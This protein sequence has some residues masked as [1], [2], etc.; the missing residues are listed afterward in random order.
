[1]SDGA[2]RKAHIV[3]HTHWDREWYL[4]Y[5]QFR[6]RLGSIV[7][8]TLDLLDEGGDF[9]H[10]LLDGQAILLEDFLAVH[11]EEADRIRRLVTA[12]A[13]SI[14][15]W[16]VLS[17]E[18]L[19]SGEATVRNLLI[20]D[21]V[22]RAF[23]GAQKEGYMPDSFGHLAQMPQ[24]LRGAGIESFIY[25]RGHGDEIEDLGSE[26][27]WEAPDGSRVIAL[28]QVRGYCNAGGL[29][30][31][32]IWHAHTPRLVDVGRAIEQVRDLFSEMGKRSRGDSYLLNNGCDHFPP[33]QSFSEILAA[34]RTAFPAT[35]FVHTNLSAFVAAVRASGVATQVHRGELLQ[36][37]EHAILSGV[38]SARM[39]LKQMN[40][41]A[42][43]LLAGL[44][45]P[46]AAYAHCMHRQEYPQ[47]E[48]EAAWKLLLQNHPHDS[49][50]GCSIDPVHREME[51]RFAGVIEAGEYLIRAHLEALVPT[52]ARRGEDDDQTVLVVFNP[53]AQR[54]SEIVTRLV[55]LPLGIPLDELALFD[56]S[57]TQVPCEVLD[58]KYV[59][60]F[61]NVDY[62]R[63]LYGERQRRLF[64]VYLDHFGERIIKE[65][66]EKETCDGMVV[67]QFLARDL[68][69]VGH[70]NY[71][72]RPSGAQVR[73]PQSADS[74][75][76]AD[77]C[78]ANEFY[79]VNLR[80]DG[81]FALHDKATGRRFGGLNRIADG[82]DIG[83]EYD[84]SPCPHPGE[85][86]PEGFIG[87]VQIVTATP[88]CAEIE[89]SGELELPRAITSD[90]S[91]RLAE[92]IACPFKTRVRLQRHSRLIEIETHFENRAHD[93]RL[94]I[95]FPTSIA[96]DTV[97]SDGQFLVIP[98]PIEQPARAGWVQSP[99]G[100]VP[101]QAFSLIEDE[102]GGLAI[103]NKGLPE[104]EAERNARGGTTLALTLLRCVDWLSRDDFPSRN[105]ANAGPTL[106]TPEA[107]C[108]G[109]HTFEYALVPYAG[110]YLS[111]G[112]T[113]LGRRYRTPLLTRQ[114]VVD[115]HVPGGV[116]LLEAGSNETV[117]SAIKRAEGTG[118]L[119]VRLCNLSDKPVEERLT[120]GRPIRAAW[121]TDL[122]EQRIAPIDI[123]AER[124]IDL[125][126]GPHGIVTVEI[127]LGC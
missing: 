92:R 2:P 11:P 62:R 1:M 23:G 46:L 104:I 81:T 107:Q 93:H 126:I 100:T 69:P 18:F 43:D 33:Q 80:T 96:T 66:A 42:Q 55:I 16:Y 15:P 113:A 94:R 22:C 75:T 40:S 26:Y 83:D 4:T 45:E 73:A 102:T 25:T 20:G 28:N 101:Q 78:I 34:L 21:A 90:R 103:F 106:Y 91:R 10:F 64:E 111:A 124:Q 19:V 87:M 56:E 31:E 99:A 53:L 35:E 61:W 98:R 71:H 12:G 88:F 74:V 44:L 38:W 32:E 27:L 116:G 109:A 30:F 54:R 14:G 119:I 13:L 79:E 37:K 7:R 77:D 121:R 59:E 105:H 5:H 108:L 115:N 47:G 112:I 86:G 122:L 6:V 82:A 65:K 29:G 63:E 123:P 95:E 52:F 50:C 51:T 76:T 8:R 70:A 36:G 89:V 67:L 84:Y 114:G 48:L 60:R 97:I 125:S 9:R 41:A 3:S 120:L 72:L 85:I 117:V 68:P 58:E 118:N 110:D 57:G 39:Y 17:D 49:I 127:E 24:I